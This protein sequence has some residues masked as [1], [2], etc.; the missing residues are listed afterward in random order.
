M[1]YIVGLGLRGLN[2]LTIEGD[3][4]LR[5]CSEIFLEGYT[6]VSPEGTIHDISRHLGAPVHLL[7]RQDIE[8]SDMLIRKASEHNVA[9]IVTGDPLSATTHNQIRIDAMRL[10]VQVEVLENASVTSVIPGRVGLLPYRMGPTVSLPFFSDKFHP[11]SVLSKIQSNLAMN[12]HTLV[13]LDLKD[14]RTMYPHEAAMELLEL[15]SRHGTGTLGPETEIIVAAK[16]SQSGESLMHGPLQNFAMQ[17][18]DLSPSAL[19]IPAKLSEKEW[20]FVSA[21]C[22]RI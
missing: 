14:S 7:G 22:R 12:L 11:R 4:V 20:E 10:G 8:G 19:V 9:L 21:F 15:E 18:L 16:V 13:L 5:S 1:L 6:S 17:N 2:S 3:M